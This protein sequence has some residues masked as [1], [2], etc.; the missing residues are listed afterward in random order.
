MGPLNKKIQALASR[1]DELIRAGRARDAAKLL[2]GLD[3]VK[4]PREFRVTL[5]QLARRTG[6]F[7]LGL[8]LLERHVRAPTRNSATDAEI[9]EYSVLL[10]RS[11][12][13]PEALERL[14]GIDD[15]AVPESLLYRAFGQFACWEFSRAVPL[16]EEYLNRGVHGYAELVARANLLYAYVENRQFDL[17]KPLFQ[18]NIVMMRRANSLQLQ[19]NCQALAAQLHVC[20]GDF[21]AARE[22]LNAASALVDLGDTNDHFLITKWKRILEAYESGRPSPLEEMRRLAAEV[23]D[24]EALREADFHSLRLGFDMRNFAHLYFGTPYAGLR[25]RLEREVRPMTG[26]SFY[27][28]GPKTAPRM[29]LMEGTIDGKPVVPPAGMINRLFG[30]LLRDLYQ[31]PRL[32]TLFASLFPNE[33][34]SI[35]TSPDRVHQILRRARLWVK[36]NQIPISIEVQGGFFSMRLDGPF[37]FTLPLHF[38]P[39]GAMDIHCRELMDLFPSPCRFSAKQARERLKL[40]K[41]TVHRLMTWAIEQNKLTRLN[42]QTRD[43]MYQFKVSA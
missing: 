7:S 26:R 4:V 31:P 15:K 21:K 14:N 37:S 13:V 19:A 42:T 18:E 5:A 33:H 28:L 12:A 16:L 40:S 38:A 32:A 20:E 9:A 24:W 1:C 35:S 17:A 25:T 30:A 43:P 29:N 23:R 41:P 22:C 27:V 6:L 8:R 11:G 39:L 3:V 34:F 2:G 36:R 10:L